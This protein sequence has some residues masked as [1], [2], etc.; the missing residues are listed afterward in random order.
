[1][2]EVEEYM[3][4][5]VTEM[6]NY[7]WFPILGIIGL[8]GNTLS[9][10]V[11][12]KPNNRKMSTCIYMAAISINDNLIM[13]LILHN[14][15]LKEVSVGWHLLQCKTVSWLNAVALQNSRYQIVVMT[16]DKYVAIK[17]PHKAATYS[18]TRKVKF[19]LSGV[20]TFTIIYNVRHIFMSSMI[21]GRCRNYVVGGVISEVLTW[22]S[23]LVNGIIP[24]S[25]L[26]YMNSVIVQ[27]V[28]NSRKHFGSSSKL[29]HVSPTSKA[30]E[31]RQLRIKSAEN[32]LTIML[33]L[34]TILYLVLQ[35]PTYIRYIYQTFVPEDTP[36][37]FASSIVFLRIT[38]ILMITNN[39][40]NFFLYCLCENKFRD[41][42]K[43]MLC[44]NGKLFNSSASATNNLEESQSDRAFTLSASQNHMDLTI[45]SDQ[46]ILNSD[47][48]S[49]SDHNTVIK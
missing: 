47:T 5:K 32:Q 6:I 20:L 13:C 10:L 41:D 49:H 17:W 38:Y 36:S 24:I 11:M 3:A 22:M 18:T 45:H 1:M 21:G 4:L 43:E 40:I 12:I 33:L 2:E 46:N 25:M 26:I 8:V 16:I 23:F 39:G 27:T 30:M 31:K 15:I 37:N 28:R 35:I 7:Y 9:F 29:E 48:N 14:W 44:C 42:L 19:I 34:V